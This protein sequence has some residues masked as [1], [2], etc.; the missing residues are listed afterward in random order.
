MVHCGLDLESLVRGMLAQSVPALAVA[1][2]GANLLDI[3]GSG[4]GMTPGEFRATIRRMVE[5]GDYEP[6]RDAWLGPPRNRTAF[7][8][9]LAMLYVLI[10]KESEALAAR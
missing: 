1:I 5:E 8:G 7:S 4:L 10:E 3:V 9:T 2:A 6:A